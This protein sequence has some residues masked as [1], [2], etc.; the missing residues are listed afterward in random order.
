VKDAIETILSTFFG[1][2]RFSV[3]KNPGGNMV[4]NHM[5]AIIQKLTSYANEQL[6]KIFFKLPNNYNFKD[7]LQDVKN[8]KDQNKYKEWLGT[9]ISGDM[10][11][12]ATILVSS[13]Q[14]L[15]D[16]TK[17]IIQ[18]INEVER[19]VIKYTEGV[20]TI[21]NDTDGTSIQTPTFTSITDRG[22]ADAKEKAVLAEKR[23]QDLA[24]GAFKDRHSRESF[25]EKFYKDRGELQVPRTAY[26]TYLEK[27][28]R[29]ET[30]TRITGAGFG[31]P[32]ETVKFQSNV[33]TPRPT[34][35]IFSKKKE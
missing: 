3:I 34:P 28:P 26:T 15:F 20:K 7:D 8:K 17:L 30:A 2:Q 12:A 35:R 31:M 18:S 21:N 33:F 27:T 9:P 4:N 1:I 6:E 23:R 10:N 14:A 24:S 16:H 25:Q 5:M 22:V 13:L 29:R 19:S 32:K 11:Q